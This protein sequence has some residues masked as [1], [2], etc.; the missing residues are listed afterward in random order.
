ME[1]SSVVSSIQETNAIS[2]QTTT[3]SGIATANSTLTKNQIRSHRRGAGGGGGGL[4][5][6]NE[7]QQSASSFITGSGQKQSKNTGIINTNDPLDRQLT[8]VSVGN[9]GIL[10]IVGK[11]LKSLKIVKIAKKNRIKTAKKSPKSKKIVKYPNSLLSLLF[12][13]FPVRL[14]SVPNFPYLQSDKN[15]SFL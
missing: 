9:L 12:N 10:K 2:Q 5:D 4:N 6:G 15:V 14:C 3:T 8:D 11:W 7:S 13:H 1:V